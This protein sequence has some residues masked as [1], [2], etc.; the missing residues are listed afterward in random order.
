MGGDS[1]TAISV[2]NH[3]DPDGRNGL[4]LVDILSDL[5]LAD[6]AAKLG[7]PS[8][9]E[10]ADTPR[11][12]SMFG[13]DGALPPPGEDGS[14]LVPMT[15]A[16]NVIWQ[17]DMEYKADTAYNLPMFL[18]LVPGFDQARLEEALNALMS[19]HQSLRLAVLGP[20]PGEESPMMRLW[21][22]D[23]PL[24]RFPL[25][26][27]HLPKDATDREIRD[28]LGAQV[29][30]FDLAAFPLC[31]GVLVKAGN[32]AFLY[33]D[34]HHM[35]ADGL[36]LEILKQDLAAAYEGRSAPVPLEG[37]A[38]YA[39]WEHRRDLARRNMAAWAE[40]LRRKAAAINSG[41]GEPLPLG[42]LPEQK[43]GRP[44][45]P[46]GAGCILSKSGLIS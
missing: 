16:Q 37:F 3:L 31:R 14:V 28:F 32:R 23:S 19:R 20:V 41:D 4:T 43:N 38:N 44:P 27:Q 8:H 26:I 21:P 13:A 46:P 7:H 30:P 5:S 29:K 45:F 33:F 35:V 2:I 24:C 22:P 11:A 25:E 17:A 18:E 15:A 12:A 40:S 39:L 36:S 1:L 6:L 34:I 9:D 42:S 10:P